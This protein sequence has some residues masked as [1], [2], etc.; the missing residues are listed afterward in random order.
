MKARQLLELY[1]TLWMFI[2][3]AEQT[4]AWEDAAQARIARARAEAAAEAR[5][6]EMLDAHPSGQLGR[7]K[8][9]DIESLKR[10]GLL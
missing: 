10:S 7:A 2:S 8:L 4:L 5:L 3:H 9:N 1:Q 6:K